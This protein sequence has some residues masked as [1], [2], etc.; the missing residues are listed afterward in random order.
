MEPKLQVHTLRFGGEPWLLECS[1]TLDAW[2]ERHGYELVVWDDS[3]GLPTPKLI[4]KEM[5]RYFL[6]GDS[7]HMLYVD[8]DILIHENAPAFPLVDKLCIATDRWH[9]THTKHF[10]TWA[11]NLYGGCYQY[12]SW[13]YANAG[14]WSIGRR[15]AKKFLSTM[16]ELKFV[17]FFQEQHWFNA[18]I[19]KSRVMTEQLPLEWNRY[20][21]DFEPAWFQHLW[22]ADKDASIALLKR[23]GLLSATPKPGLSFAI[24]TEKPCDV[25]K[26]I[27]LEFVKN[28]GLGN[29]MFEIAAAYS[30]A[31]SL[32]LPLRWTWNPSDLREF[33]LG[34]FGFGESPAREE[35]R[36]MQKL[37]Q[38]SRKLYELAKK[39]IT[40]HE[41]DVCRISCPFQDEQCFIDHA[42]DIAKL[43]DLPIAKLPNPEGT[44]AV[45][46]QVRRG[47]Y[48]KHG[49]LNVTT[50]EYFNN[51]IRWMRDRLK[52]PHF[53]VVS[54][55]PAWCKEAFKWERDVTVMP[56]QSPAEGIQTL[57]SCK[58]HIIS[59]STFGWWGA[60]LGERRHKGPVVVPERWHNEKGAYGEWEPI[61]ERW[62][63]I[64]TEK[65]GVTVM[66]PEIVEQVPVD[67]CAIVYPW[68]AD[69]EQ[70]HE[71]RYSL[72][73]ADQYFE[74]KTCPIYILGTAK[75]GWLIEGGRVKYI[76]AYTYAQAISKG[77]QLAEKVLW[78]NDD[79]VL[80][81]STTW[82]DCE[83][84]L[85]LRDVAPDFLSKV[86]PQGNAWREGVVHILRELSKEGIT[87]QKVFSTHTPYVY[88]REKALEIIKKYGLWE[89]FPMEL[90]Y[91]HHHAVNPVRITGEKAIRTPFGDA[92]FL[93]YSDKTLT[94]EMKKA[95]RDLF[96]NVP[97]WEMVLKYQV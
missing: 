62:Q 33:E 30:L 44:T 54:D 85:Y 65:R 49:R 1:A 63:R 46:V 43:F 73:S 94:E 52:N 83:Q 2:C 39:R 17:E 24:G 18:C 67:Q 31:R 96:P 51:G 88:Q 61:P 10:R 16:E 71:L 35:P 59:N 66:R 60:W 9:Q 45:G 14:V 89:K 53:I 56:P 26:V 15:L 19:C 25:T 7:S 76:G 4:Q 82:E 75:P 69:A 79:I 42:K 27:E 48:L 3:H 57:A 12:H 50:L 64:S 28:C 8:A 68:K 38:G 40:E 93:G 36:L 81:K 21:R 58:A 74:D 34:V 70:W 87:E 91:F 23:F 32:D 55:D 84:T 5:L 11:E 97:R 92:R 47:D 29:Q 86:V 37:G 41:G 77:I 20:C 72:R 90:A 22:G 6:A 95:I 78:M 80:L 13:E